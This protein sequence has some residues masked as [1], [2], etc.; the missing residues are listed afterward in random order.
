MA[1]ESDPMFFLLISLHA[2][3]TLSPTLRIVCIS[4]DTEHRLEARESNCRV[5]KSC[6]TESKAALLPQEVF[7]RHFEWRHNDNLFRNSISN[8]R[9]RLVIFRSSFP[10]MAARA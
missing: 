2:L 10:G 9:T 8:G 4:F 6:Y 5:L 1:G 3:H 7:S